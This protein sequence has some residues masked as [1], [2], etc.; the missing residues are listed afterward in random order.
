MQQTY[1]MG[2]KGGMEDFNAVLSTEAGSFFMLLKHF[3][4]RHLKSLSKL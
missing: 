4:A 2:E 1:L 3:P